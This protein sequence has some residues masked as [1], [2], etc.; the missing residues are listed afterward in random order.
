[1]LSSKLRS[2]LAAD[3]PVRDT[4]RLWLGA[5]YVT[6]FGTLSFNFLLAVINTNVARISETHVILTELVLISIALVLAMTRSASFIAVLVLFLSYMAFIMA[7]RPEL[8]LKAFRDFL[9]PIA[10]YF[11]GRKFR[12]LE[13]IDRLIVRAAFLVLAIGLFE[14]FLLDVYTSLV[15]IFDYYVAKGTLSEGDNFVQ[16]STLFVSSTRVGG[17]NFFPFLGQV[18][19]SSVFLE[20][21]T[22][23]NFGAFLSLWAFARPDCKDR[24]LLFFMS[25]VAIVLGDARFGMFVCI[26]FLIVTVITPLVS[27]IV[28]WGLFFLISLALGIYGA[29]VEGDHWADSFTGRVVHSAQLMMKLDWTSLFGIANNLPFL[30]DNGFAYTFSQIGLVGLTTLWSF[31]VFAKSNQPQAARFK[32]LMVTF[33][34]LMMVVSNSIYSIKLAALLWLASGAMDGTPYAPPLVQKAT[35]STRNAASML[36]TKM[37]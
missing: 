3:T 15:N 33:I 28:W 4:Y 1:M 29:T 12:T 26:A 22:M 37:S 31:Y 17:R 13:D 18:R 7:L 6:I 32:A 21:V 24:Y 16:G 25:F 23:G 34:C 30:D 35:R 20:P 14:F 5:V 19:A 36:R 27:R 9:I 10:F 2:H 11:V 8:D